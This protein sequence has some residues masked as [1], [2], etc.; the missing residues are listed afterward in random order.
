MKYKETVKSI[1]IIYDIILDS[2]TKKKI[3]FKNEI[4]K[5]ILDQRKEMMQEINKINNLTKELNNTGW[6]F[7]LIE[8]PEHWK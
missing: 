3:E 7:N 1:N 6:N 5:I 2:R 8:I 4:N